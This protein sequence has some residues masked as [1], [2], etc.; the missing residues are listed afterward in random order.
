ME[1]QSNREITF[2]TQLKTALKRL[3]MLF[4]IGDLGHVTSVASPQ[5]EEGDCRFLPNE[6]LQDVRE[7]FSFVT[8]IHYS[9]WKLCNSNKI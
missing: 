6:I 9:E 8:V 2:E 5:V 4:L 3:N 7:P 1:N